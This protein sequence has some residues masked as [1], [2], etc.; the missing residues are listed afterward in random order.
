MG[1]EDGSRII[2]RSWLSRIVKVNND[3]NLINHN[4]L[5]FFQSRVNDQR[6]FVGKGLNVNGEAG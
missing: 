4:N 1:R 3:V 6:E 5:F 2:V